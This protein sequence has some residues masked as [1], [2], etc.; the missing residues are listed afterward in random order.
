MIAGWWLPGV[1]L[2]A[3][4]AEGHRGT[5]KGDESVLGHGSRGGYLIIYL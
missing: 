2:E 1:R 5:F 4:T 3:L